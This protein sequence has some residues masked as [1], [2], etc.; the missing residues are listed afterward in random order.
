[1]YSTAGLERAVHV[2]QA[3]FQFQEIISASAAQWD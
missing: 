2:D 3:G 1:M